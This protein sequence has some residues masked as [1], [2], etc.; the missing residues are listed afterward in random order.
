MP[1]NE[2]RNLP[3]ASKYLINTS[4]CTFLLRVYFLRININGLKNTA[5]KKVKKIVYKDIIYSEKQKDIYPVLFVL[6]S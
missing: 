5:L 1:L 4:L 3:Y 2:R 6:D